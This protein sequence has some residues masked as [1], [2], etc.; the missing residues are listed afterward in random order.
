LIEDPSTAIL[1]AEASATVTA[2][3]MLFVIAVLLTALLDF[4][5][6]ALSVRLAVVPVAKLSDVFTL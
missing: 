2:P 1:V 3:S 5:S 4:V 6:D